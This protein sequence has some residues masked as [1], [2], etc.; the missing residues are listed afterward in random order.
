MKHLTGNVESLCEIPCDDAR[1]RGAIVGVDRDRVGRIIVE[2]NVADNVGL[3]QNVA[4]R[5]ND[6]GCK[7][8]AGRTNKVAFDV[9]TVGIPQDLDELQGGGFVDSRRGKEGGYFLVG[10]P[11]KLTVGKVIR[12]VQGPIGPVACVTGKEV[13][14]CALRGNCVFLPMWEKV[15]VAVSD[16]YDTT[17][18]QDLVV[19]DRE[20]GREYVPDYTI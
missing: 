10:S 15:K 16:I 11:G 12:F 5:T 13:E 6:Q 19:Q 8:R 3:G 7:T 2:Q 1:I 14:Q 18:F 17:S 4:R 9:H 20:R